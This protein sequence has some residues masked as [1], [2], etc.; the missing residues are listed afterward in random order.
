MYSAGVGLVIHVNTSL[1][2]SLSRLTMVQGIY[3][4]TT[5][6]SFHFV[7]YAQVLVDKHAQCG[8]LF[9]QRSSV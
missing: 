1:S 9:R 2:L 5:T 6:F 8:C 3:N 4:F 7:S